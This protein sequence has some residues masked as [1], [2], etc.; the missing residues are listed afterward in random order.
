MTTTTAH[1]AVMDAQD[2]IIAACGAKSF[3]V[4]QSLWQALRLAYLAE[5]VAFREAQLVSWRSAEDAVRGA[6]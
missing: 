4:R 6:A 3:C 2:A 1:Q 5:E